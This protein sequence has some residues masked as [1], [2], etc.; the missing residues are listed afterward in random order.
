MQFIDIIQSWKRI[1]YHLNF[2]AKKADI[3]QC[4]RENDNILEEINKYIK[5]SELH[6]LIHCFIFRLFGIPSMI[7]YSAKYT[8]SVISLWASCRPL[9]STNL[10]NSFLLHILHFLWDF[11]GDFFDT[12]FHPKLDAIHRRSFV[13]LFGF[14]LNGFSYIL[15]YNG[16]IN[17]FS[18]KDIKN[19]SDCLFLDEIDQMN[20]G[21]YSHFTKN[22]IY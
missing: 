18:F 2:Y 12:I 22:G 11:T 20:K 13:E 21:N 19:I 1:P 9:V 10:L 6:E 4:D 3:E 17:Y 16:G 14:Y 7:V 15:K 8:P 5:K